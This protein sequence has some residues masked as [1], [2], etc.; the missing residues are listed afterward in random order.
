ME[1]IIITVAIIAFLLV[2]FFFNYQSILSFI[3]NLFKKKNKK[4]TKKKEE[5]QPVKEE[6]TY[7]D[8][9]PIV[10]EPEFDRDSSIEELLSMD[11]FD[12]YSYDQDFDD[13]DN[14]FSGEVNETPSLSNFNEDSFDDIFKRYNLKKGKKSLAQQIR[15]LPPEIKA[16]VIDNILDK[17]NDL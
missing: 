2:L 12:D 14:I 6:F 15:E 7:E 8:F 3:K 1:V 5:P 9:K 17:K 4:A 11:D 10:K 16:M 13:M